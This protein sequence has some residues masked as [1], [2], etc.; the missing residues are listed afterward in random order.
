MTFPFESVKVGPFIYTIDTPKEELCFEPRYQGRTSHIN[1][2]IMV[3]VNL[4]LLQFQDTLLHEI[5]HCMNEVTQNSMSEKQ[6]GRL[7]TILLQVIKDNPEIFKYFMEDGNES[8]DMASVL[9][10]HSIQGSGTSDMQS[11]TCGCG[12][13]KK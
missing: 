3:A 12:N 1:S 9:H 7:S 5:I 11:P 2:Q 8:S 6:V 13:C 10:G 4:S